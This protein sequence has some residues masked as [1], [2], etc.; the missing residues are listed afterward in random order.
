V[1]TEDDMDLGRTARNV[2]SCDLRGSSDS[3]VGGEL[4]IANRTRIAVS[5]GLCVSHSRVKGGNDAYDYR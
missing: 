1:E 2:L 4:C 5:F 3:S